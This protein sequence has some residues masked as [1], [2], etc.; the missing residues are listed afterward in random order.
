MSI[1]LKR[2]GAIFVKDYKE[3]SRNYA[4]SFS[5]IVPILFAFLFRSAGP[6]LPGAIGFLL[7]TSFVLLTC[8]VQACLIAEEKERNT[9]RSLM[10][11]PATTLD[12]LIGK[13]TLVF[14]ISSVALAIATLIFGYEPASIW[15]F[16]TAVLFSIILY[17]A[18]GTI[19]G[20]FSKTLLEASLSIMPVA[21]VFTAAPWGVLLA[22]DFPIFKVL[23]YTPSVQLVHLLDIRNIGFT[24]ADLLK[25]L[26]I[27]LAWTIA[28][29]MVSVVLYQRRLKDE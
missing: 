12:V 9:L 25:P 3:F 10:M 7:N 17:T 2:A 21:L 19:C 5:L 8:L 4:I 29:T 1:S 16:V 6:S 26:L 18:A 22:D 15:A 13:S 27:I 14:I 24:T 28:L 23:E 11:T 20:L